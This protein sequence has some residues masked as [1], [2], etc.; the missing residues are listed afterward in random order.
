MLI[1]LIYRLAAGYVLYRHNNLD[2]KENNQPGS[3]IGMTHACIFGLGGD[4][5]FH[6]IDCRL[7]TRSHVNIQVSKLKSFRR[8]F[9]QFNKKPDD[10]SLF[11]FAVQHFP[12]ENK[13]RPL[14]KDASTCTE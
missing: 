13:N 6:C 7:V 11:T 5:D 10:N 8:G 3:G 1:L 4:V 12:T 9:L 14:F 2:I